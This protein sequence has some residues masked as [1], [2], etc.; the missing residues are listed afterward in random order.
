MFTKS[1]L[2]LWR[3]EKEQAGIVTFC[4]DLDQAIGNGISV[5]LI[6]E[7]CGPPGTGKTQMCIQL[8]VNVQIPPTLGGLGAKVMYFDTNFGFN[9][10]RLEEVATAC[11][12][13]CQKLVQIHR[14]DLAK[15]IS[16]FTVD[17]ILDGVYYKHIHECSE[18]L[19]G[20]EELEQFLKSGQQIK[21][22]IVD[23]FSFLIRN[24]IENT[25]QRIRIGHIILTKLH[26]LAHRYKC[27]V[28][29][30]NDVTTRI[31][32]SD[33]NGSTVLPALGESHSHKINQRI[34]LGQTGDD[35]EPGV[36]I[37]SIE[38]SLLQRRTSVKFHIGEDGIR[39]FRKK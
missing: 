5:G 35:E 26:M 16:H 17:S 15:T 4:K 13:H 28:I 23:S 6:T 29:I 22:V 21:L 37:A 18:L 9:P 11:T 8:A 2:D 1:C 25:L 20:I 39:K 10:N 3:E 24:N 14:K 38:K 33:P 19:D 32:S 7:F 36:F 12:H 30:T 31:D 27:A 34:V